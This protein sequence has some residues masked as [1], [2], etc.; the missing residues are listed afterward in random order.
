[1]D[2]VSPERLRE[3]IAFYERRVEQF[4]D[5]YIDTLTALREL[6]ALREGVPREPT[7]AMKAAGEVGWCAALN[8]PIPERAGDCWRAM[9]DAAQEGTP[10]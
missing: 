7:E 10:T 1:V 2:K 6:A 8:R 3:L 4:G 9:Y 5:G